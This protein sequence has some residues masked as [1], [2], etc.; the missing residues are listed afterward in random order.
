M[1]LTC[2]KINQTT[3]ADLAKPTAPVRVNP[4]VNEQLLDPE[5]MTSTADVQIRHLDPVIARTGATDF[6]FFDDV[7]QPPPLPKF[8]LKSSSASVSPPFFGN[9]SSPLH[10]SKEASCDVTAGQIHGPSLASTNVPRSSCIS[11][12]AENPTANSY[13]SNASDP[14]NTVFLDESMQMTVRLT[15][16][17]TEPCVSHGNASR[18]A[19]P[20]EDL[21]ITCAFDPK[22][23]LHQQKDGH[24][25]MVALSGS[26]VVEPGGLS[27]RL[28]EP[29]AAQSVESLNCPGEATIPVDDHNSSDLDFTCKAPALASVQRDADKAETS[30]NTEDLSVTCHVPPVKQFFSRPGTV[31]AGCRSEDLSVTCHQTSASARDRNG[32]ATADQDTEDLSFTCAVTSAGLGLVRHAAVETRRESENLSFTC[33]VPAVQSACA[34]GLAAAEPADGFENLSFTCKVPC[35]ERDSADAAPSDDLS[36]TC[37]LPPVQN[38]KNLSDSASATSDDAVLTATLKTAGDVENHRKVADNSS[39]DEFSDKL[40]KADPFSSRSGFTDK[41]CPVRSTINSNGKPGELLERQKENFFDQ[42]YSAQSQLSGRLS[43]TR[44]DESATKACFED[45]KDNEAIVAVTMPS[46]RSS[47]AEKDDTRR[48]LRSQESSPTEEVALPKFDRLARA[49][50]SVGLYK[51][52]L[53]SA[54]FAKHLENP[55]PK[56]QSP[57]SDAEPSPPFTAAGDAPVKN[58]RSP[59]TPCSVE[60]REECAYRGASTEKN[61]VPPCSLPKCTEAALDNQPRKAHAN[62]WPVSSKQVGS[63]SPARGSAT[64]PTGVDGDPFA[65]VVH[66]NADEMFRSGLETSGDADDKYLLFEESPVIE[67][68][69]G[70]K[71]SIRDLEASLA[72]EEAVPAKKIERDAPE[73]EF[74]DKPSTDLKKAK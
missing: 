39:Q 24:G 29:D 23:N 31:E 4:V 35:V 53:L 20:S 63:E 48:P 1:E 17:S 41:Q 12:S 27:H 54:G 26:A 2:V 21:E 30:H 32:D 7:E 67:L 45:A 10:S 14:N 49:R 25:A 50:N 65:S 72:N 61:P 73:S 9:G 19:N 5:V 38:V 69:V 46:A 40:S 42:I 13:L 70:M 57:V 44:T 15:A 8:L 59:A 47:A 55:R 66:R 58:G 56:A 74:A 64:S 16:K 18:N 6:G 34:S 43:V 22:W 28:A 60:E 33:N 36:F 62:R 37:K 51:T 68:G 11:A 71:R 3:S 52:K